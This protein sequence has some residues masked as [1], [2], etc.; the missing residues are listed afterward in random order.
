MLSRFK[1]RQLQIKIILCILMILLAV[2]LFLLTVVQ[3]ETWSEASSNLSMRTVYT[4][5]PRG[6]I[7]DRY[8]RLIAGNETSFVVNMISADVD[9]ENLNTVALNL[10]NLL[11]ANGDSYNDD[12]PIVIDENGDFYYTYDKEVE[13]WLESQNFST[14]LTAQEAFDA[15][16]DRE[17]V[18][19][20]L[21]EF[22]AQ[23]V[24]QNTYSI[25]PPISVRKMEYTSRIE[26]ASFLESVKVDK[27]A[28]AEEAFNK[29]R[30]KYEIDS[31]LSDTDARKILIVRNALRNLGL[32]NYMPA[33]IATGVSEQTII[34]LEE[35]SDSFPG[36]QISREYVRSYPNF[37]TAC[38]VIGYLGKISE[39][40]KEEYQKKGYA[41]TDVIGKEGIEK[42]YESTLK[43]NPGTKKLE[44]NAHGQQISEI[45]STDPIPGND[46]YLTIDLELQ[47]TA[48]AALSEALTQIQR[49]GTFHSDYGSYNYSKAYRNANVGAAV[50]VDVNS[51]EILALA[52]YPGYDPNLFSNGISSENWDSLQAENERDQL[53]PRPLYNVATMTSVQ[54][55]STFKPV[56]ALA[57]LNAGLGEYQQLYDNGAI[58]MGDKSF[59]CWI[60]NQSK[61]RH[62]A[63]DVRHALEVSCNYFC[64]D[65]GT[66]RDYAAGG[67]KLS[68]D[69]NIGDIMDYAKRL[70]LGQKTGVELAE[71]AAGVMSEERKIENTKASL[72]YTLRDSA[73]RFFEESVAKD[74]ERLDEIL[75]TI[76]SWTE[77][78]PSINEIR[79][80][81]KGMNV[82]EDE[83]VALSNMIKSDY[84]SS[85]KWNE[86]DAMNLS[87]GQGENMFTPIQM[88]R[89]IAA[90]ANNGTLYDLTLTKSIEGEENKENT[91]VV[92]ENNNSK[93][94]QIVKEGMGLVASGSRGTARALFAGF[95]WKVG[96]K[97]GTAQ[98]S[99]KINPPDEVEY[100]KTHLGSI[101]PG[102]SFEQ[103]E[104][105][106]KRLL[107]EESEIYKSESTAV[108]RA[109]MNLS[110]ASAERIDA[111]K[112]SYDNFAW[113]VAFG[114]IED[115]QIAVAVMIFQGGSGGYAGPVA[116]EII[117]KY[118][119]LQE[120]YSD[121]PGG[122]TVFTE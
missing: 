13:E 18:D 33:E 62:G 77:E 99:G 30:E 7:R 96:A 66:G 23:Q 10:I 38:H 29:L 34:T 24:L 6:E 21:D 73:N 118:M 56:T 98:K 46:V 121:Y 87:I 71:S 80:R 79:D 122:S 12:L 42:Y 36:V 70:G 76:V 108:R 50:A 1:D 41:A 9:K 61:G 20:G 75:N 81:L 31:S 44:V 25:Y 22:E 91:G 19:K 120:V 45:N 8:G 64:Y 48:E 83:L 88:A 58:I 57:G 37:T 26:L 84:F 49:G 27:D 93:A 60:W 63:L 35:K 52:N 72:K 110:G 11:E 69:I 39:S 107:K 32:K 43:G 94:Y 82:I 119:E 51:G 117:G 104:T 116:R 92:I 68:F 40:E 101:A 112:S 111:Y 74:S 105:E 14:D 95:P 100:I 4:P 16:R 54:P 113:F 78:N 5:A 2:R 86:G 47:K 17:G 102:V 65:L 109:V 67:R 55:G 106:M 89:Y 53:S 28:D 15:L 114:P 59:G 90:V 115:P 3:G 97:T 85:A 103:V